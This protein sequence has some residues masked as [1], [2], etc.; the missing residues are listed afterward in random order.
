MFLPLLLLFAI[1]STAAATEYAIVHIPTGKY[2]ASRDLC[3]FCQSVID[4]SEDMV[5]TIASPYLKLGLRVERINWKLKRVSAHMFEFKAD[6]RLQLNQPR[7]RIETRSAASGGF[8]LKVHRPNR[9]EKWLYASED[10]V[11]L[12]AFHM[13][14]WELIPVP[15]FG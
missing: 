4:A 9:R 12:T 7:V 8:Y 1:V 11:Y 13:C 10:R 3:R 14:R 5:N 15:R 2:L 6:G